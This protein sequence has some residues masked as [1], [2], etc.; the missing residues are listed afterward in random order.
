MNW[1]YYLNDTRLTASTLEALLSK[2][3]GIMDEL[4]NYKELSNSD[5]EES[6]GPGDNDSVIHKMK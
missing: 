1:R 2:Q 4:S 3:T 5:E 6:L